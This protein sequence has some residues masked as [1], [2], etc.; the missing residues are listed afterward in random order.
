MSLCLRALHWLNTPSRESIDFTEAAQAWPKQEPN[1]VAIV[2]SIIEK[3]PSKNLVILSAD[4]SIAAYRPVFLFQ[5]P[6]QA[7]ATPLSRFTDR[8][9]AIKLFAS[10]TTPRELTSHMDKSPFLAPDVFILRQE[11]PGLAITLAHNILPVRPDNTLETI[12]FN[13]SA[14]ADPDL[15]TAQYVDG[16]A[17]IT[18]NQ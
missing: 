6:V 14:F 2:D 11:E 15:F 3:N 4:H 18:R 12:W 10:S 1:F 16:L 5:A 13:Q 7:Y 9:E 17:I 8:N